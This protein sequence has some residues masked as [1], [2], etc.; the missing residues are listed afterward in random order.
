MKH[1]YLPNKTKNSLFRKS[2]ILALLLTC[3]FLNL[4]AQY[5]TP[6]YGSGTGSGDYISLVEIVGTTLNSASGAASSPYYTV[7]PTSGSTTASMDMEVPYQINVTGG[8]YG[9]CHITAWGDWNRNGVFESSEYIGSSPNAGSI[10]MVNFGNIV[11]PASTGP[12]I[13]RIRFRSSDTPPGPSPNESC[14]ST[15]SSYGET[16]DYEITVLPFPAC[17]GTPTAGIAAATSTLVCVNQPVS[18]SLTGVT[19][20]VS[21]DYQW[22]SS[23]DNSSWTNMGPVQQ[24]YNYL[25]N[26]VSSATYYRCIVTCTSTSTSDF[27]QSVFV[28]VNPPLNCYCT[29]NSSNPTDCTQDKIADFSISNVISQPTNCDSYGYSDST[30][31]NYTSVNLSAG[32]T[33]TLMV[34]TL[35][36]GSNGNGIVGAWIDYNQN[37]IFEANEYV[38]VGIGPSG[39]YSTTVTLPITVNNGVARMRL[40]LDAYYADGNTTL[41]ACTPNAGGLG[42]VVDY[43]V[44]FTAAPGCSG[45]P[46]AGNAVSTSTGVCAID[47]YTLDLSG[48]DLV[49]NI[50]YQW[51]SSPDGSVWTNLGPAQITI[52]HAIASQTAT[53]WYRCVTTCTTSSL[54]GT[55]T[56]VTVNQ[57]LPTACYCT[58]ENINCGSSQITNVTLETLNDSPLC[59]PNGYTDN[60]GTV[61]SVSL[62]ANQSYTM[63]VDVNT[64]GV[65]GYIGYWI[66]FNQNGLF[67]AN[68]Y[69]Y[70]GSSSF[71]PV[72]CTVNVPFTALG[73]DTRMR[74]KME[75]TWG[76]FNGLDPCFTNEYDGQTLDYLIH[77]TPATPCGGTP[78]AGN[79]TSTTTITCSNSPFTLDLTGNDIAGN[80]TYQWQSS[81]DN[82]IWT[83]MGALQ[84]FVPYTVSSQSA[85]MYYRCITTCTTTAQSAT[86]TPVAVSQNS[87][88]SC[89]CIPG[90]TDCQG[91]DEI[92]N[93]VLATLSNTSAC[94]ANL[95]GYDD[96]TGSVASA[97]IYALQ[98]Y[99]MDVTI[100]NDYDENVS[101]WIDFDHSGTFDA[102][103]YTFLGTT[104][105]SGN[106]T[107]SGSVNIPANATL[108]LTRMRVRNFS[109]LTLGPDDAC[110]TPSGGSRMANSRTSLGT[111]FGET[112][113][114]L[115]DILPPDCSSIN[116]PPSMAVTGNTNICSGQLTPLDITP[117]PQLATGIT[118][119][120]Y[121]STT[122]TFTPEGSETSTSSYT[123]SPM[124]TTYYYCD[125]LCNGSSVL[126]SNT[127]TVQVHIISTAP[128]FTN[129]SCNAGCDGAIELNASSNFGGSLTYSW[130]PSVGSAGMVVALCAGTYSATIS[131][132]LGCTA[133]QTFGITQPSAIIA[134][135]TV[136]DIT[137]N[138]LSNGSASVTASGGAGSYT[139]SWTPGG[140]TTDNVSGLSAGTYTYMVSDINGCFITNTLTISEPAV[141]TESNT[142]TNITCFG[143]S[144]GSATITANGG[145]MPY[146]YLWSP[147]TSTTNVAT[148]LTAGTYNY[149][150]TDANNCTVSNNVSITTPAALTATSSQTNVTC[151]GGNDGSA[152][153]SPSGGTVASN[154]SYFWSG[155]F[156]AAGNTITGNVTAQ[157]YTCTITDDNGCTLNEVVTITEPLQILLSISGLNSICEKSTTTYSVNVANAVGATTYTWGSSPSAQSS[158]NAVFSYTAPLAS[159]ENVFV[160]VT[161]A[162]GCTQASANYPVNVVS[163]T[164]I[165]GT[166]L[167]Q[168]TS[169]PI[170]GNVVLYKYEPFFTKFDSIDYRVLDAGGNYSF[171][172]TY[173]GTYIVKAIPT[174]TN[175]QITYG[176][177]EINWKTADQISHGCAGN[178][179]QNIMAVPLTTL[180]LG[181]TGSLS[182]TIY[183]G[184]G[185]GQRLSQIAVPGN[186]IGGII[187]KGGKNP[188]GQMFSQT[189]TDANGNYS[190]G[191]LPPGDYFILVDI[192]GL[193]TN[194]TYHKQ[195]TLT[196]NNFTNLDFVV[197]SARINPVSNVSVNDLSAIENQ[198]KVFPNPASNNVHIQYNLVSNSS[199]TIELYDIFGKSVRTIQPQTEQSMEKHSY[200]VPVDDL[201]S[202]MYF[203]K[204]RI[205]NAES[206]IK[207]FITN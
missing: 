171:N 30:A 24:N 139:Y 115:V 116:F 159:S 90:A 23:P 140:A 172:S 177:S 147:G 119:Q 193:D 55:S 50:S 183:E 96:Y 100:G 77:I 202:G 121:S 80:M 99:T 197:D 86:S 64:Q 102:S 114:Y 78:N 82:A 179:I 61:A 200:T 145:T 136:T 187:V 48:N 166:V 69:N 58:P 35:L 188:G 117:Q 89:Y 167:N 146:S 165:S 123:A 1:A 57:N 134:G 205:N 173:A 46:N 107:V 8:T 16:E 59:D 138:G 184:Q 181:G 174:A 11:I 204:L 199:V 129:T 32:N 53:T 203:V 29:I 198:I 87:F 25:L 76:S 148:G 45:A 170:A 113:D 40:M 91:G 196:N 192:P 26:S 206:V 154:Y 149:I 176:S 153:V 75:S 120:W 5:C 175:I 62:T 195:I 111:S 71:G 137:C 194:S 68:E 104:S 143:L 191:N 103:E 3:G 126:T 14:G 144:D 169:A 65:N 34:N 160:S 56:P 79:A 106:Y 92:N 13:V 182:G 39:T 27:S 33:Y 37:V 81:P 142:S 67:D 98:T 41:T 70:I 36:S 162:N 63:S 158:N 186:P 38:T 54:T 125:V 124:V 72:T 190:F 88:L 110:A 133:T 22:Q 51:Q 131:N 185:Y 150:V 156:G 101:V 28:D 84:S 127:A 20:G 74:V 105:G 7:F 19:T 10:T 161:D 9:T 47:S 108:G 207:L 128:S 18:L 85:L 112:E 135:N 4:K 21:L 73:G 178:A 141:L 109:S 93:V 15:N 31:S 42:Q 122:S 118:Y 155:G 157:S 130:T 152:S 17:S 2:A 43:K 60:T 201:A 95:S 163:S 151:F 52:P 49:S 168:L 132:T 66:D 164:N 83:N 189:T 180:A 12:G 97:T 94:N 44:N 6:Y